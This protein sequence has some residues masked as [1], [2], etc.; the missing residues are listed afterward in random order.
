[1]RALWASTSEHALLARIHTPTRQSTYGVMWAHKHKRGNTAGKCLWMSRGSYGNYKESTEGHIHYGYH[2][3]SYVV[4]TALSEKT[5]SLISSCGAGWWCQ[6]DWKHGWSCFNVW[7]VMQSAGII[8]DFLLK[9]TTL[10]PFVS[11]MKWNEGTIACLKALQ[12][13]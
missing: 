3:Q 13:F 4:E 8:L 11:A 10:L 5:Q 9:V 6:H 12:R 2:M 7:D 1:M